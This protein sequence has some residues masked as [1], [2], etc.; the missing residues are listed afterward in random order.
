[1]NRPGAAKVTALATEQA[2]SASTLAIV[3]RVQDARYALRCHNIVEVIPLVTLRP[4]PQGARWLVGVFAYRG[5]LTPV[6][7]LCG[8]IGGYACPRRLSSRIV[9]LRCKRSDGSAAVVGFLAEHAT[10]A[11]RI[12]AEALPA[13]PLS[14]ADYLAETLLDGGELLQIIDENAVLARFEQTEAGTW[15]AEKGEP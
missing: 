4:M 3:F 1:M 7:D 2:R 15:A 10:E 14:F 8:L 12:S 11:R 9:L 5:Q 6:I 13:G